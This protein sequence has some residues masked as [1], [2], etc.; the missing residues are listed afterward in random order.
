[1]VIR[2]LQVHARANYCSLSQYRDSDL[3]VDLIV[4]HPDGRWVAAEVKL[5]GAIAID[6]AARALRRL[7]GKLDR[8]NTGDPAKLV[9]TTAGGYAF[10]RPDGVA[11]VPITCLGP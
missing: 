7:T 5:G 9:V 2:D 1:M 6:K 3:E 4:E 10:E 11:V 8:A